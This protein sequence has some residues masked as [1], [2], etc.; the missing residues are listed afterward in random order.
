MYVQFNA[1]L[2]N[3]K[4]RVKEKDVLITSEATNAQGWIVEG[5]DDEVEPGSGLTWDMVGEAM[6]ADEVLLPR[7]SGRNVRELDE[8]EFVS[9]DDDNE[10]NE[11]EDY[12][13]ESDGEQV[14]EGYGEEEEE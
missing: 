12:E 4:R 3:K 13:F 7:R 11:D 1:K 6:G 10:L 8:D 2:V 5:G 9:E 14:L